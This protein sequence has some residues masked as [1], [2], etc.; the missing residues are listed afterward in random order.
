MKKEAKPTFVDR[1]TYFLNRHTYVNE[2]KMCVGCEVGSEL[3][4]VCY[5]RA[6][7][8]MDCAPSTKLHSF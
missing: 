3:K 5:L 7:K 1:Y 4:S 6:L 2:E 8:H